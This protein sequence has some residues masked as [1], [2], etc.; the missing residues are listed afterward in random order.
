MTDSLDLEPGSKSGDEAHEPA[1]Q[2]VDLQSVEP[3]SVPTD[4]ERI[5]RR[6]AGSAVGSPPGM[7]V[8]VDRLVELLRYGSPTALI[9]LTAQDH[10]CCCSPWYVLRLSVWWSSWR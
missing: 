4:E 1:D 2:A 8:V 5:A 9:A 3:A 6:P 7:Q 10:L